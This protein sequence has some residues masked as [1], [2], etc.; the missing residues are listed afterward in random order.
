MKTILLLFVSGLLL[1]QEDKTEKKEKIS[2]KISFVQ[3]SIVI[4]LLIRLK[5]C[6][7]Y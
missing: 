7:I 2:I 4:G 6:R 5:H 3:A 1:C